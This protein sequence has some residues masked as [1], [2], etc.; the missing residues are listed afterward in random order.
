MAKSSLCENAMGE[1]SFTSTLTL[2]QTKHW[3][4][5]LFIILDARIEE[6]CKHLAQNMFKVLVLLST[7]IGKE[8]L[9]IEFVTTWHASRSST[10][11]AIHGKQQLFN[12][13]QATMEE[14]S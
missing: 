4:E 14:N 1:I 7:N 2:L 6:Y 9:S 10:L 13:L 3:K 8:Q 12:I 11:E 5:Q